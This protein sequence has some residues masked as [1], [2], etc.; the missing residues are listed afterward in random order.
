M[1]ELSYR[2]MKQVAWRQI[3]S[4]IRTLSQVRLSSKFIFEFQALQ[5]CSAQNPGLGA[6][7]Q[8][9]P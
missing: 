3:V 9:S 8:D 1:N 6:C 7:Q 5:N 2:E 4:A